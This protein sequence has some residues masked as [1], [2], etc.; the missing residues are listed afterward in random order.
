M[1]V[2]ERLSAV[3]DRL[4]AVSDRLSA[5]SDRFWAVYDRFSVVYDRICVYGC[6]RPFC[7]LFIFRL[8]REPVFSTRVIPAF[9]IFIIKHTG[10]PRY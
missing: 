3:S 7:R 4:S 9:T 5:V 6:F 2:S 1:S 8:Q 10:R